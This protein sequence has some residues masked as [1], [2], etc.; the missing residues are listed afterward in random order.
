MQPSIIWT[1]VSG[2]GYEIGPVLN[3]SVCL[4]ICLFVANYCQDP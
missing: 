2:Q 4:S 1:H 3:L